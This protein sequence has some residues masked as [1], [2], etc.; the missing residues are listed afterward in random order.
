MS[1]D[2]FKCPKCDAVILSMILQEKDETIARLTEALET[3]RSEAAFGLSC[4][5]CAPRSPCSP[6][7][8][9]TSTR[10]STASSWNARW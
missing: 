9:R 3:I 1:I 7:A 4:G 2:T 10:T 6:F 8:R 5:N